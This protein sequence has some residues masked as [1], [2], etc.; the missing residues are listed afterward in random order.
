MIRSYFVI[1]IRYIL[2]NKIQSLIQVIS[3]TIGITAVILIGL[4]ALNEL[5]YDKFNEK[6][7]R[8]FRLEYGDNVGQVTAIGHEI[9]ENLSVVENVVRICIIG[10]GKLNMGYISD[11]GKDTEDRDACRR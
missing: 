5:S 4:Y 7:D 6:Y 2:R 8:I 9:K 11:K 1:A 10:D 3:L